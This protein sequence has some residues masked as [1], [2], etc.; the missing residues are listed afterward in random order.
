M[1][2]ISIIQYL[3]PKGPGDTMLLHIL[4][5]TSLHPRWPEFGT[6]IQNL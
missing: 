3:M 4:Y 6:L 1:I 5:L 2:L